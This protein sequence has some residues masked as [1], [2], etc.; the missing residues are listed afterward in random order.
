MV[1]V[2][3]A[4]L[5]G[6]TSAQLALLRTFADQAAI[7]IEN[8]RLLGELQ[9]KN[10]DL[11][12]AL[13]QQ[14]ATSEIL[15]VISSSPTDLQPVLDAVAENAAKLCGADRRGMFRLEDDISERCGSWADPAD[16]RARASRGSVTGAT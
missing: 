13:E 11:T 9:A 15:R 12:E 16:L 4:Q 8:A 3:R 14:T 2:T 5:G 7:A 1:A 6:F 10:A